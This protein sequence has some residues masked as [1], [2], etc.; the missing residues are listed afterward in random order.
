[1][2]LYCPHL[3]FKVTHN[4]NNDSQN[5][6]RTLKRHSLAGQEELEGCNDAKKLISDNSVTESSDLVTNDLIEEAPPDNHV[7]CHDCNELGNTEPPRSPYH[8]WRC[9]EPKCKLLLCGK[10]IQNH[11]QSHCQV[12]IFKSLILNYCSSFYM[13]YIIHINENN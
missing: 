5:S 7:V 11:S 13:Q 9:L 1:M 8:L 2:N 10:Q 12:R 6:L 3:S 4:R